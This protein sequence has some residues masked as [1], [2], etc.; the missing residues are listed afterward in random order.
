MLSKCGATPAPNVP[1]GKQTDPGHSDW[2]ISGKYVKKEKKNNL[3]AKLLGE[4]LKQKLFAT[5]MQV[6]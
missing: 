5:E 3:N 6:W 1:P 4:L 2:F